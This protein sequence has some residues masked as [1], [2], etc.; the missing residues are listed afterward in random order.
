MRNRDPARQPP[1]ARNGRSRE[2]A[3]VA[4]QR[5]TGSVGGLRINPME[6]LGWLLKVID[7]YSAQ[8]MHELLPHNY[9]ATCARLEAAVA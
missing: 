9:L 4:K 5:Q 3:T 1:S 7:D 8:R 6:Y 2:G